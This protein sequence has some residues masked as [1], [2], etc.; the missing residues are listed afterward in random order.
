MT[1]MM[2]MTRMKEDGGEVVEERPR[3][4]ESCMTAWDDHEDGP[5][6]FGSSWGGL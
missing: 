4:L 6:G 2:G 5:Y 3:R 1:T